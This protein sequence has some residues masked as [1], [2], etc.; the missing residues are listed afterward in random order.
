MDKETSKLAKKQAS[1]M[2]R[3]IAKQHGY[4][5]RDGGH[6]K[7]NG[8]FFFKFSTLYADSAYREYK[9][10]DGRLS[11][12]QV[13]KP[14]EV[15]YILWDVFGIEDKL[16]HYSTDRLRGWDAVQGP[17]L[18]DQWFPIED[19]DQ[20]EKVCLD[21]C[22]TAE[23]KFQ[24]FL[25][26]IDH[27]VRGY[28]EW[29]LSDHQSFFQDHYLVPICFIQLGRVQ[30]LLDFLDTYEGQQMMGEGPMQIVRQMAGQRV[31]DR[32]REYC[33]ELLDAG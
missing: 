12:V 33:R 2:M 7:I 15:D 23:T 14:D 32:F 20:V 27:S 3:E 21:I 22:R 1:S 28:Y 10:G 16:E 11:L 29:I 6:W 17:L 25:T 24:E 30:E 26:S 8:G 5:T 31:G 19:V 4:K 13:I 9:K 18:H